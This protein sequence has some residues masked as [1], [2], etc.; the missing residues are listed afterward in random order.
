MKF[1]NILQMRQNDM[2]KIDQNMIIPKK[3]I[4]K[5]VSQP[6]NIITKYLKVDQKNKKKISDTILKK[7]KTSKRY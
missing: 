7:V 1:Q 4:E 3:T 2:K 5:K 6:M